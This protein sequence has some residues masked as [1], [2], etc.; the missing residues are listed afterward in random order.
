MR[1]IR[2]HI[3]KSLAFVKR[4]ESSVA[5]AVSAR[6]CR[7]IKINFNFSDFAIKTETRKQEKVFD[8]ALF[9]FLDFLKKSAT[10]VHIV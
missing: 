10:G 6:S 7:Y 1:S 5:A 9:M 4:L 2:N 3:H 8:Q